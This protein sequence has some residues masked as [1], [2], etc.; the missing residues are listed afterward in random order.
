MAIGL[1]EDRWKENLTIQEGK[2]IAIDL[3]KVV[4]RR[5][6]LSTGKFIDVAVIKKDSAKLEEVEIPI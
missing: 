4:S 2:R 1:L 5:D 6:I 3:L